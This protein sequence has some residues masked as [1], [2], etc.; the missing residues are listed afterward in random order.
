MSFT[1]KEISDRIE[2]NNRLA[3]KIQ[4]KI[5]L[6]ENKKT[7]QCIIHSVVNPLKLTK[8]NEIIKEA[9]K[10]NNE[11]LDILLKELDI[12]ET[13]I[14]IIKKQIIINEKTIERF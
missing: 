2:F 6:A 8:M 12:P 11:V 10:A 5:N 7:K 4:A 14:K 13:Y 3:N 1:N 9:L